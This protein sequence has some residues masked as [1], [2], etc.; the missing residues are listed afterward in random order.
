MKYE[1]FAHSLAVTQSF[2]SSVHSSVND[3]NSFVNKSRDATVIEELLA[4]IRGLQEVSGLQRF[5][6]LRRIKEKPRP[7][8]ALCD[9]AL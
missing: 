8:G 1:V 3:A 5:R 6:W 7:G 9:Y 2:I 4:L